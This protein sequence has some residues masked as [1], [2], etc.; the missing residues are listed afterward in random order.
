MS[1]GWRGP[2]YAGDFPTLGP[3]V[4]E[5]I[6]DH[7]PV[8]DGDLQGQPLVLSKA[9]Q[10]LVY[11][12]YRV[13]LDATPGNWRHYRRSMKVGPKGWGKDP[14]LA[15]MSWAEALGPVRFDGWDARGE[16]VGVPWPTPWVQMV[17]SSE[18]QTDNTYVPFRQ[19][20]EYGD[21]AGYGVDIGMTRTL[22]PGGG[23]IEPVTSAAATREGQRVTFAPLGET[24]QW[25]EENGGHRLAATVRRNAAK[26]GGATF[27]I[28]N[29]WQKGR[30]SVAER[31]AAAALIDKSILVEHVTPTV[32]DSVSDRER[33]SWPD[34]D[35][36][37]ACMKALREVYEGHQ[38]VDLRRVL[39]DARDP[40]VPADEARRF[41]F[42]IEAD[43]ATDFIDR[44]DWAA[45]AD[46]TAVLADRDFITLGFDGAT[47]DDATALIAARISDGHAFTLGVWQP[48]D[49]ETVDRVAV[50]DAVRAAFDRYDVWRMYCDPPHWQD[51][52]DRWSGELGAEKVI[53][54]WTNRRA[55]MGRLLERL[56]TATRGHEL[57]HDGDSTL[58]AHVL[59][60]RQRTV[61]GHLT[62]GKEHRKSRRKI[63]ACVALGLAWEARADAVSAGAKP[64]RAVRRGV[65][66]FS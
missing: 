35:N 59:A 53:D 44:D 55:P 24:W 52:I 18:D 41:Y 7:L 39:A 5:W 33:S 51:Y 22:L 50:D 3:Q 29:M 1:A 66:G 37:R 23:I 16:P 47:A 34:L 26:M 60:A 32:P 42:N 12:H 64:A 40:D 57:R 17:G 19:M 45:C 4:V 62:I 56:Q 13:R 6:H 46:P 27:E 43:A 54:W 20:G 9:Q 58:A 21:L 31:T 28:T 11:L 25:T 63:D 10:R 38:W 61:S 14:L 15:A 65:R 49:G 30:D 48:E 36:T 8:P 2:R